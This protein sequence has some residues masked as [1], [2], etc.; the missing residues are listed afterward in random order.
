MDT[1]NMEKS[2][3]QEINKKNIC[4]IVTALQN[5]TIISV[6]YFEQTV[7]QLPTPQRCNF[8][9][10]II[11]FSSAGTVW[12]GGIPGP[13]YISKKKGTNIEQI[14]PITPKL[15]HYLAEIA[16]ERYENMKRTSVLASAVSS[17]LRS[18]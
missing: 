15:S 9:D 2:I 7:H 13:A 16:Q 11:H 6:S 14:C 1:K 5:T 4:Y 3:E 8:D 17:A 18:K 10:Y 12:C